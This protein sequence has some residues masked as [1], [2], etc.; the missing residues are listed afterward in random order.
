MAARSFFAALAG[1]VEP[2]RI[3]GIDHSYIFDVEG[4]GR[5]FVEVRDGTIAVAESP[6]GDAD[7]T[8]TTS[9]A[10]FDR[11]VAGEQNPM[12]AYMSGKLAISGD[13][14]AAMKLKKLF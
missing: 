12:T 4:E 10:T 11:I 14:G 6:E 1:R 5:W 9:S 3:A 7:V 13:L 2:D 8:I